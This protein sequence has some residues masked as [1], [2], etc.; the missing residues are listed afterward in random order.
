MFDMKAKLV[1]IL[2]NTFIKREGVAK[3]ESTADYLLAE[4]VIVSPCKVGAKIWCIIQDDNEKWY[5]SEETVVDFSSRGIYISEMPDG[6]GCDILEFYDEI[7][8]TIF[9]TKEGAENAVRELNRNER[10]T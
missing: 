9:L 5:I 10:T 8:E 3:V 1:E 4:G 7:G 6:A 2:G